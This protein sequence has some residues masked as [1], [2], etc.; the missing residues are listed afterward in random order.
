[1][2]TNFDSFMMGMVA[3]GVISIIIKYVKK[4]FNKKK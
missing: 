4:K 2:M 1:M 3:M